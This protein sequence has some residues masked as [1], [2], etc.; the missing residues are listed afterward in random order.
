MSL[1]HARRGGP[2]GPLRPVHA[3]R[4]S[5]Y[6]SYILGAP[7]FVNQSFAGLFA[8]GVPSVTPLVVKRDGP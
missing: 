8:D 5:G 3:E 7:E 1:R 6:V 4:R 2:R